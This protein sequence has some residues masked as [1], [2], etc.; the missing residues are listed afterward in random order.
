M[1]AVFD[2]YWYF[3]YY[4]YYTLKMLGRFNPILGQIWTNPKCWVKM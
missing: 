4:Y 2:I 3:M 1:M